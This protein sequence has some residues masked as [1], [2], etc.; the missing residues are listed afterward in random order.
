M[1]SYGL[2]V[3]HD[4]CSLIMD[5][6]IINGVTD[7]GP[8]TLF[9]ILQNYDNEIILTNNTFLNCQTQSSFITVSNSYNVMFCNNTF[10]N[11]SGSIFDISGGSLIFCNNIIENNDGTQL[12][13]L[14]YLEAL[15]NMTASNNYFSNISNFDEGGVYYVINSYLALNNITIINVT[16][17]TWG[18][19]LVGI[20]SNIQI[21][22]FQADQF[23]KGCLQFT[24][25]SISIKNSIFQT[26][27][28]KNPSDDDC[29]SILCCFNCIGLTII[30]S[31][32]VGNFNN[33][34]YG[35]VPLN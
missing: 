30:G 32:F 35:G 4:N 12:G 11:N 16:T 1:G 21:N 14:F 22:H 6:C 7:I 25:S 27:F 3:L 20:N 23:R 2:L 5:S 15:S 10:L 17:D 34:L 31:N 9:T 26:I 13:G 19:C 24:N 18:G 33:T 29:Y 28:F 8:G